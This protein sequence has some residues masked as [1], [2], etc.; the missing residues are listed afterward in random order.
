MLAR[1]AREERLTF[2]VGL[3]PQGDAGQRDM[4]SLRLR[5]D[6]LNTVIF[7]RGRRAQQTF[8]NL[9]DG[10]LSELVPALDRAVA[11]AR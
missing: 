8:V 9:D 4:E 7:Y 10:A 11:R 5:P 3:L 1:V 6:A 2:P